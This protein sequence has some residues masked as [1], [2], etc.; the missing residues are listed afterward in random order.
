MVAKLLPAR[1]LPD[2]IQRIKKA[3]S[4]YGGER[5]PLESDNMV[6]TFSRD[7]ATYQAI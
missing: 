1:L 5:A 3:L 2:H 7:D 4:L 6:I